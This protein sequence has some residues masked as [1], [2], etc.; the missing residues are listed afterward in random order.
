MTF[1][2]EE[3][4]LLHY[5]QKILSTKSMVKTRKE[6]YAQFGGRVLCEGCY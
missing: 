1:L 5:Q 2:R 4:E 6:L 3:Q